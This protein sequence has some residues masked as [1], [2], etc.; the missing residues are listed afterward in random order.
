MAG[1]EIPVLGPVALVVFKAW[2]DRTKD[3]SDIEAVLAAGS[4]TE[5][6]IA[7]V[8]APLLGPED[9]RLAKLSDAARRAA[10]G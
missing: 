5:A 9:A 10:D 6:E 3:W 1:Q 2:Y 7:S 4:T 8:L